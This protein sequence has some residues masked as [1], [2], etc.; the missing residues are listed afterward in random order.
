[1]ILVTLGTQKQQFNRLLN[2]IEKADIQDEIV[3]QAGY[4]EY[5]S[6]KMKIFDFVD[7]DTMNK[8]IDEADIIITHGGTGSITTPLKKGKK[9]IACARLAK[10]KEHVDD[11]QEQLVAVFSEAGYILK[12]DESNDLNTILK[13]IDGFQPQK[14]ISNNDKFIKNISK[15]IDGKTSNESFLIMILFVLLIIGG[16]LLLVFRK[17]KFFSYTENRELNQINLDISSYIDKK[18]QDDLEL[19]LADQI[20][21]SETLKSYGNAITN[22]SRKLSLK[23]FFD[24]DSYDI[25]PESKGLYFIKD[26]DYLVYNKMNVDSIKYGINKNLEN[27]NEVYLKYPNIKTYVY[28]VTREMEFNIASLTDEEFRYKLDSGI[29]YSSFSLI[30]SYQDYQKYYYKSDHHWNYIGQYAGYKEIVNL[31]GFNEYRNIKSLECFGEIYY[32]GSKARQIGNPDIND[33]FCAYIY[34]L[35]EY[36]ATVKDSPM[37]SNKNSYYQRQMEKFS[38]IGHYGSFYGLDY[39]EIKYEY[40]SNIDKENILMFV[41][42]FSNPI[43]ELIASHYYKS[44]VVDLRNYETLYGK[45]FKLNEYL[46]DKD[47]KNILFLGNINFFLMSDFL[48][49][50]GE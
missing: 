46:K 28:K 23:T 10:Y 2:Y 31:L 21:L 17:Q 35:P 43:N 44:Y 12:L 9:V 18:F 47:I 7:Y 50:I 15:E 48:V 11:H 30:N 42:S 41:D 37:P 25:I 27:I 45:K 33:K 4:T 32:Y 29:K 38:N 8:Y 13:K 19:A 14:F 6:K 24:Y 26:T 3:V 5:K 34:D 36:K 1:M 40:P 22:Q 20:V 49:D 16:L 39:G